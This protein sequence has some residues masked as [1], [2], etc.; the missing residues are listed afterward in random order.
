MRF[1]PCLAPS[2]MLPLTNHSNLLMRVKIREERGEGREEIQC[3]WHHVQYTN[4]YNKGFVPDGNHTFFFFSASSSQYW[5]QSGPSLLD[6]CSLY[7]TINLDWTTKN[8]LIWCVRSVAVRLIYI[9]IIHLNSK[10]K[11]QVRLGEI[12]PMM[13]LLTLY[14]T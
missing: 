11:H 4:T 7:L 8:V 5:E 6:L 13:M 3:G 12:I 1:L 9:S 2:L 10:Y 14:H